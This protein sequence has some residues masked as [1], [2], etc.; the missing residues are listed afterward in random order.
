MTT[1]QPYSSAPHS[2]VG[3][4]LMTREVYSPQ[5]DNVRDV[6]VWLSP[7]YADETRRFP[8]VYMHDGLNLFDRYTSYSGEW[9]VDETMTALS[10][11]GLDAIIVG[12]PNMSDSRAVEYCPYPFINLDGTRTE[13]RGDAYVRFIVDTVKPLIDTAFRTNP[14][15][16]ATG[17][18]G[19]SM[20]GL[21]SLYA[22]L[23]YPEVFGMC[24]A[25][26]PAY[27]FGDN[28]LLETARTHAT[29][30][31]RVY[32]DVGTREGETLNR[33]LHVYGQEADDAYTQG[34]RDLRDVLIAR[35]Y[36][37]GSTLMYVE[38]ADATHREDAWA[39]RFPAAMRFLLG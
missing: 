24:G 36:Q 16:S 9:E 22:A 7:A 34:V 20:G 25:F 29:G 19:S 37:S 14:D 4:L 32:L 35:G 26:S 18:A 2:V 12:L 17:I 8:V 1:W 11:E 33:W 6:F 15:A 13:G 31:G 10:A 28:G 5:L 3:T 30:S 23:T 39:R 38:E 21:I 27:W